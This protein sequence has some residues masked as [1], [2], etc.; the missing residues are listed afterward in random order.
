M[1][2]TIINY[3]T[4]AGHRWLLETFIGPLSAWGQMATFLLVLWTW[5]TVTIGR[6][7]RY[8][9]WFTEASMA[10]GQR[11]GILMIDLS[12]KSNIAAQVESFR[13][14]Q[15]AL[16]DI[17]SDRS[18]LIERTRDLSAND[19]TALVDELR[20]KQYE[21]SRC[22]ID[23]VHLFYAG[24]V[25]FAPIVGG[26]LVNSFKVLLYHRNKDTGAYECWGAIRHPVM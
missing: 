2:E 20:K 8:R 5:Y 3:W 12:P 7:W 19:M 16:K 13:S 23:T 1:F 9:R 6:G 4:S 18:F 17:T 26:E 11:P 22:G 15:P 14:Q 25:A 24:P 21:M 10:A